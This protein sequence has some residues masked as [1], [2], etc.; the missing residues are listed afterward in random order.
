MSSLRMTEPST[1]GM[2]AELARTGSESLRAEIIE[3]HEPLVRSLARK[4]VRAGVPVDDLVQVA[5]LA[6]IRAVDRFEPAHET[7]FSTYATHCMVGEIKR[8]FR[9]STWGLKVPRLLHDL[10]AS[11]PRTQDKLVA[12][13]G[14]EPSMEEMATALGVSEDTLAEA[15][16]MQQNYQM[17]SLDERC[18]GAPD[19]D[20]FAISET[21]GGED[22]RIQSLIE[23][24]PVT[25]AMAQLEERSQQEVADELGLSQ[26][27]ISRLE[28]AALRE[29]R[30]AL[31]PSGGSV[32]EDTR[33]AA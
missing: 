32:E 27:H 7:K 21:I 13:L 16:E 12:Q 9:D 5:W 6:L 28:R 10:A 8:Y 19:G 1:E 22:S 31:E 2:F 4:F 24:A 26:M 18:E 14:R 17:W 25:A 23:H 3:R 20:G 29:M 33:V 30:I 15:M 11:L